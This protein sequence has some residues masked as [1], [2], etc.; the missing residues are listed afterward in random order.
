MYC[1]AIQSAVAVD[2]MLYKIKLLL[3]LLPG[4]Y[5]GNVKQKTACKTDSFTRQTFHLKSY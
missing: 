5:T 3:L 2:F 4:I 1:I